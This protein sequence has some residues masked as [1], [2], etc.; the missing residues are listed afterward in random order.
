MKKLL[1]ILFLS[2]TVT[3]YGQSTFTRQAPTSGT[4]TF[5]ATVTSYTSYTGGVL[6]RFTN[7][8]TSTSTLNINS[9]GAVDLRKWDGDSWEPLSSGD[10]PD[11]SDVWAVYDATNTYFKCYVLNEIGQ[12]GSGSQD[13][14]SV[15]TNGNDAGGLTIENLG[16]P[17]NPQDAVTSSYLENSTGL[18]QVLV[19]DN[20]AGGLPIK[21]LDVPVDLNDAATKDYVDDLGGTKQNLDSDLTA[22]A[23]L[24]STGIITRTGSGTA[25]TRTITGTANQI[26]VTNGDGV[27]GNP[28]IAIA[29]NPT[30]GGAN[31]TGVPISTGVSGLGTGVATWLATPSWTNFSSAITGTAPFWNTSGSTTVTTPTITGKPTWTQSSES[32]TN[33]FHTFTQAAHTGGSPVGISFTGGAHTGLAAGAEATD[34]NFNLAR[35]V[36]FTSGVTIPLQRAFSITAPTYSATSATTITDAATLALRTPITGTN[37]T[38]TNSSALAVTDVSG[39]MQVALNAIN[40]NFGSIVFG[41]GGSSKS[42]RSSI[43]SASITTGTFVESGTGMRLHAALAGASNGAFTFTHVSAGISILNSGTSTLINASPTYTESA[44]AGADHSVYRT[45][46]SYT[47]GGTPGNRVT[48]FLASPTLNVTNTNAS[49]IEGFA[50]TP[51][52]TALNGN[53]VNKAF[54]HTSGF[55]QWESVLTPSQITSNQNDYNPTGLN[56]GGAPNGASIVRMSS[57]ASRNVTSLVGGVNGRL[58]ILVNVGSNDIVLKDDDGATGTAA[59]RFQFS[60]D[61]TLAGEQSI[62]LWYDGTSSRWRSLRQ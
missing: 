60:A 36:Q 42:V 7:A 30:I 45:S 61:I 31:I 6:L 1:L 29:T 33:T 9:L 15:L 55:V 49:T 8:N 48:G 14:E 2:M 27:S 5:T 43:G 38:I 59:N 21:D 56:N 39:V 35:T 10:I 24:S 28:T 53:S 50:Y 18:A 32:S 17:V 52:V 23:G 34:V 4:N 12:G 37:M 44:S 16:D 58:I 20:S 40:T 22:I 19:R 26:T 46:F 47:H 51:T 11:E 54:R 41:S 25:A 3:V 62:M 57:D 13:L